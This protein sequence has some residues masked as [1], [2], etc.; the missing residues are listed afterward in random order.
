M[1][2]NMSKGKRGFYVFLAVIIF[3]GVAF[4]RCNDS[5]P[6]FYCMSKQL[7]DNIVKADSA[8]SFHSVRKQ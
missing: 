5:G 2:V 4:I 3:F 7:I 6:K 8:P 1:N